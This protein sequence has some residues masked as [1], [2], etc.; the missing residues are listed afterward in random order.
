LY[1]T[2]LVRS[3][4]VSLLTLV[5]RHA[6]LSKVPWRPQAPDYPCEIATTYLS[7][8]LVNHQGHYCHGEYCNE[9][10]AS[11]TAFVEAGVD[12]KQV[13]K[14][15]NNHL[16]IHAS[17]DFI[18][19]PHLTGTNPLWLALSQDPAFAYLSAAREVKSFA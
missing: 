19:D 3:A 4:N 15:L 12:I 16:H 10:E 5:E 11:N 14:M 13:L 18:F 9:A 1:V 6:D 7:R 2:I 17:N 8:Y